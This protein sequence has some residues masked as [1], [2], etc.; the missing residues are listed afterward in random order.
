MADVS[1]VKIGSTTYDIKDATARDAIAGL[2]GAMRFIGVSTTDPKGPNGATVSGHTDWKAGDVVLYGSKE[3]VLKA[4]SNIAANWVELGDESSFVLKTFSHTYQPAGT[5]SKPTFTGTT[6]TISSSGSY[7]P[8]GS[9]KGAHTF[10]GT[11]TTLT[12]SI[13]G[14]VA[15]TPEVAN[16][17]PQG[18]V[19]GDG[20]AGNTGHYFAGTTATISVSTSYTPQGIV[21]AS[22]TGSSGHSFSGTAA[23]INSSASYTPAGSVV[24]NATADSSGHIFGGMAA[25][26]TSEALYTPQGIV[27]TSGSG[28]SG[29]SFTGTA[30]TLAHSTNTATVTLSQAASTSSAVAS[31]SGEV[32]TIGNAITAVGTVSLG[33]TKTFV[34]SIGDHSYTPAGSVKG[35]HSWTGAQATITSYANYTPDGVVLGKHVFTGTTATI[36][37]TASYT[38]A[39]SVQ[40]VHSWTGGYTTITSTGTYTPAGGIGG[41]HVFTG[42]GAYFQVD[43]HT[44]QP[45]GAVT[46]SGTGASGHS[47]SGTAGTVNSTASY[48]PAG[49]VSQPTFT[50]TTATLTHQ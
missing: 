10:T 22:G 27:S 43:A 49:S 17:T 24:G 50:G 16:Y 21:S 28:T 6:A 19:I 11:T 42:T 46:A 30:A 14:D 47:F 40:G 41:A 44:Y 45:E 37:S 1:Q 12:H 36:N 33:G 25:T 38:P 2:S 18:T 29:H 34:T 31:V 9:V 7:T 35:V 20:Q 4:D 3:Y 5:V 48:Q 32:L 23:T 15:A 39:G 26:I 8:A 13:R